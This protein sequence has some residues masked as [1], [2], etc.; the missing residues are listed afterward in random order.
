MARYLLIAAPAL[1]LLALT[2]LRCSAPPAARLR[3]VF[4]EGNI[5]AGK[6][7]LATTLASTG[8]FD[9][10]QEPVAEW[11]ETG[12]FNFLQA[13]TQDYSA[14]AYLFQV[15]AL[16]TL[17]RRMRNAPSSTRLRIFERSARCALDVFSEYGH[18]VGAIS[19]MEME[20]LRVLLDATRPEHPVVYLYVRV[21]PGEAWHRSR[22]RGRPEESSLPA[23]YFTRLHRHLDDWLLRTEPAERINEVVVLDGSLPPD[24]LATAAMEALEKICR[25]TGT[26]KY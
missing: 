12:G 19:Q 1:I 8:K 9:V 22:Q 24:E 3:D 14:N 23:S 6:S 13:L 4:L 10:Y 7:T 17:A 15:L 26:D 20:T 16:G 11:Q 2:L 21:D 18:A 25:S 5:G